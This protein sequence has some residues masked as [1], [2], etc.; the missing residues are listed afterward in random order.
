MGHT[1]HEQ[2][3]STVLFLVCFC[4]WFSTLNC[5]TGYVCARPI[6]SGHPLL[7]A[8]ETDWHTT[9]THNTGNEIDDVK[10]PSVSMPSKLQS[11]AAVAWLRH[12]R[13]DTQ[14]VPYTYSDTV[15]LHSYEQH[16]LQAL[17][18]LLLQEAFR[19]VPHAPKLITTAQFTTCWTVHQSIRLQLSHVFKPITT[20][21]ACLVI[22]P[23]PWLRRHRQQSLCRWNEGNLGR[24]CTFE[25]CTEE[26]L[27]LPTLPILLPKNLA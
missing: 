15:P 7:P 22:I 18:P 24:H 12:A 6:V 23:V 4:H 16:S 8:L 17:E 20:S 5:P 19:T 14:R 26:T 1:I 11:H 27:A 3:A 25:R 21:S 2:L 10:T 9:L 13:R